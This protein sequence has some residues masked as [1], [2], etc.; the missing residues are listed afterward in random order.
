MLGPKAVATEDA[1][2]LL[3]RPSRPRVDDRRAAA[4]AAEPVDQDRDAVLGIRNLLDIVAE[5]R[6]HD[7]RM[8]DLEVRPSARP[9]S[10]AVVGV[11]VAVMPRSVGSPSA[12]S[13]RRMKR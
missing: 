2:K 5:V 1:S 4:E 11:A 9:M 10:R 12:S 6:T 3:G 7:A 8:H 13:P